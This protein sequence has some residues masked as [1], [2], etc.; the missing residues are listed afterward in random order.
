MTAFRFHGVYPVLYAFHGPDGRLDRD[1]MRRQVEHCIA[2]GAHGLMVLG[3]VTEVHKMDVAERRDVVEP[4]GSLNAGPL[5]YAVTVAEPP[6]DGQ[7]AFP[8]L[9]QA[10]APDWVILQPPPP[11]G[12]GEAELLRL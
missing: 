11:P 4:V 1:A 9:A 3:L 5:P 10:T 6:I 8:R 7:V 2:S 12:G